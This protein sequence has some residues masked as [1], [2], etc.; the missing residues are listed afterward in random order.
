[1][2]GFIEFLSIQT[3]RI[4]PRI[5][6][7]SRTDQDMSGMKKQHTDIFRQTQTTSEGKL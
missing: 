2:K 7:K 1:M 4:L 6:Y 5:I 3:S